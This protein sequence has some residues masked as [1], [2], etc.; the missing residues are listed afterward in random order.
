VIAGQRFQ[1]TEQAEVRQCGP[2]P[3]GTDQRHRRQYRTGSRLLQLR[4]RTDRTQPRA[5]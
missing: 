1:L 5:T 4:T 3:A 2:L